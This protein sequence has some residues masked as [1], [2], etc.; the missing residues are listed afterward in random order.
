[1]T[2][3]VFIIHGWGG[4]PEEKWL[5]WLKNE[6]IE[7]RFEIS[8]PAMPDTDEPKINSWVGYL[9]KIVVKPDE[10]TYFVGHSIGCQTIMRYLQNINTKIGGAIF[11]AGWFNLVNIEDKE[12]E[13]IA[14]PW[15]KT[16]INLAKTKSHCKKFISIFSENDPFVPLTD[17]K[18]FK[19][20]LNAKVIFEKNKGHY[21]ENDGVEKVPIVLEELLKISA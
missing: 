10:N 8:V 2:K 20:K 5:S 13:R 11:V 12:S 3:R 17:S 6:L 9:S 15:L 21:T 19:E 7:N 18:I 14:V 1:M 4:H 16:K